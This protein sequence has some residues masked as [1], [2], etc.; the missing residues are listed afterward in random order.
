MEH[1]KEALTAIA[2]PAGAPARKPT[3]NG[4]A[5]WKL[6]TLSKFTFRRQ[7]NIQIDFIRRRV[8]VNQTHARNDSAEL[9]AARIGMEPTA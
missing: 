3:H 4:A 6:C 8:F 7:K 1:R 2:P 9:V 5:F